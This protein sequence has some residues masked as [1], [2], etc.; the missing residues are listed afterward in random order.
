MDNP[1]M[2]PTRQTF[3]IEALKEIEKVP[4]METLL[5]WAADSRNE[6]EA[7]YSAACVALIAWMDPQVQIKRILPNTIYIKRTFRLV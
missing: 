2:T 5:D 4:G 7:L 1:Y 3:I 6:D